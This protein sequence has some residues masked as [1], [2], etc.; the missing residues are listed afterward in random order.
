MYRIGKE[1][2]LLPTTRVPRFVSPQRTWLRN[3]NARSTNQNHRPTS[4]QARFRGGR[5]DGGVEV[6]LFAGQLLSPR[7]SYAG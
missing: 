6:G 1:A 3:V 5:E 2:T 4:G 7:R